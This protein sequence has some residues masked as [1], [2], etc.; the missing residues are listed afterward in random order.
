MPTFSKA[1]FVQLVGQTFLLHKQDGTHI[2]L[3][4]TRIEELNAMS[5]Y[6]SFCLTFEAPENEPALPD[7]SYL[8]END[9]LGRKILFLSATLTSDPD[10]NS[11]FYESVFNIYKNEKER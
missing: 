10:P 5:R 7:N 6:E 11:Y 8:L 2:H 1:M 3:K 4:L 9:Q